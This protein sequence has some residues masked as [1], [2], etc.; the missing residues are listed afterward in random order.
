MFEDMISS[1]L[2]IFKTGRAE[3]E[4]EVILSKLKKYLHW[5]KKI[6]K[7]LEA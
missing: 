5:R 4:S 1:V 2:K 7:S 6:Q 3:R